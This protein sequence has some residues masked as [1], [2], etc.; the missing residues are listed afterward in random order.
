MRQSL[1]W[2]NLTNHLAAFHMDVCTKDGKI[3]YFTV[4]KY[5]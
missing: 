2:V 1:N 4:E 3:D 5:V